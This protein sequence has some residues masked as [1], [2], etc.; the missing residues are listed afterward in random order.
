MKPERKS[1]AGCF[2]AVRNMS[3]FARQYQRNTV[4]DPLQRMEPPQKEKIQAAGAEENGLRDQR[5]VLLFRQDYGKVG[6]RIIGH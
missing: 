5:S 1:Y 4:Y 2:P 3:T 6:A